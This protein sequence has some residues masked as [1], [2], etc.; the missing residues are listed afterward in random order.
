MNS[1]IETLRNTIDTL[2]EEAARLTVIDP[3]TK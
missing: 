3:T 1:T 2:T